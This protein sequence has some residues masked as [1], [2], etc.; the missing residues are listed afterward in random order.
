[1]VSTQ[2]LKSMLVLG[3]RDGA[4]SCELFLRK[5]E[6]MSAHSRA[7]MMTEI[8]CC[9]LMQFG[10]PVSLAGIRLSECE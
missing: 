6:R 8:S 1:M 5:T 3:G 4:V 7:S 9:L 2:S 10:G